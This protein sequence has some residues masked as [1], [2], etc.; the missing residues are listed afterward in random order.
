MQDAGHALPRTP[1]L[2]SSVSALRDSRKVSRI[3][4]INVDH[5]RSLNQLKQALEELESALLE[6]EEMLCARK[7]SSAATCNCPR[8]RSY[9]GSSGLAG[10]GSTGACAAGR[11]RA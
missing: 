10:A 4:P 9:T 5:E 8:L 6:F 2:G 3:G 11:S 1:L 7:E